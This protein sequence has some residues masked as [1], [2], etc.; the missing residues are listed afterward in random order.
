M[1][2]RIGRDLEGRLEIGP[3]P[4]APRVLNPRVRPAGRRVR[5]VQRSGQAAYV[6]P[7][8]MYRGYQQANASD[9]AAA[10]AFNALVALVPIV[11]LLFSVAGLILRNDQVLVETIHA[12]VWAF[13]PRR[14]HDALD[15]ILTARNN[16]GWFGAVSLIGF[17]WIGTN[18]VSCLA[19]SM[20]HVYDVPNRRFVHQRARD[21]VVITVFAAFFLLAAVAAIIPTLFVKRDL[22]WFFERWRLASADYQIFSY[23]VSLAAAIAFFLV[24]YRVVPN[25][26]QRLRDVWPGT[27]TAALLFVALAQLFPIYFRVFGAIDRYSTAFGFVSLLVAWFYLLAHVLLFGTY[28]NATYQRH[29]RRGRRIAGHSLP[30]CAAGA[31]GSSQ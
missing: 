5:Y 9:L 6:L 16:S 15:A 7:R 17:A 11:L 27:L 2:T 25:A 30:G 26:G 28:V 1:V 29:C 18:F 24:L 19:R 22:S 23:G 3:R 10:V 20:N 8:W 14:T 12:S 21:F 13:T 4:V 31:V